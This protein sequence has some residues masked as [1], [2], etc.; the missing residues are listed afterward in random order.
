MLEVVIRA[1]LIIT[2]KEEYI[3]KD[4]EEENVEEDVGGEGGEAEVEEQQLHIIAAVRPHIMHK[5]K[6]RLIVGLLW[7]LL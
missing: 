5:L 1:P 4:E 2:G 3:E 7:K 6:S